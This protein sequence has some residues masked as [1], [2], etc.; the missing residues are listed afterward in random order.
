MLLRIAG[1][2][3]CRTEVLDT[4]VI[5]WG[6]E[7]FVKRKSNLSTFHNQYLEIPHPPTC[8]QCHHTLAQVVPLEQRD[9]PFIT[10]AGIIK[11]RKLVLT[12]LLQFFIDLEVR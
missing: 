11:D 3:L 6:E 10:G 2:I 5:I 9:L 7:S 12:H 8:R 1:T 4:G